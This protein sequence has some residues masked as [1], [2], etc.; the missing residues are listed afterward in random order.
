MENNH[1][2]RTIVLTTKINNLLLI[3]QNVCGCSNK[4]A[5][6]I[7][8]EQMAEV[9]Y[10]QFQQMFPTLDK[11]K[12]RPELSAIL[13]QEVDKFVENTLADLSKLEDEPKL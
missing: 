1:S 6:K 13:K 11:N 3:H 12:M 9:G 8:K 2:P 10:E 4:Q 7:V 5:C